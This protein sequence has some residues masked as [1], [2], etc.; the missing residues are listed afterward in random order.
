MTEFIGARLQSL[1]EE[2]KMSRREL[3]AKTGLTEAAISRYITG[4][5]EP[6]T[7]TLSSIAR[8]L[9]VSI[10][11]LLQTPCE[12]PE[13]LNGAVRLVARSADQINSEQK[14]LLVKALLGM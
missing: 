1:L 8:A 9:D 11:E 2:R 13:T 14:E 4:Q 3:S 6:R 7:I 10:D 5:R 12:D